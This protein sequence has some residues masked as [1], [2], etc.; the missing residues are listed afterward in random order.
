MTA[1]QTQET[2]EQVPVEKTP[3]ELA[4]AL[5][6]AEA[7]LAQAGQDFITFKANVRAE[8]MKMAVQHDLCTVV[9]QTLTKVGIGTEKRRITVTSTFTK[10]NVVDVPVELIQNLTPQTIAQ[11]VEWFIGN[12]MSRDLRRAWQQARHITTNAER[13][14]GEPVVEVSEVV[15]PAPRTRTTNTRATG[16]EAGLPEVAGYVWR[17]NSDDAR[18]L[19][20]VRENGA[21]DRVAALCSTSPGWTGWQVHS[22]RGTGQS[23][24]H[25]M[26][27]A[28]SRGLVR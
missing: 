28:R 23:C 13:P 12:N 3:E 11:Q 16:V 21:N 20:L 8:A 4:A 15:A 6:E 17:Y 24:G 2:T 7:K 9:E 25:C 27:I 18:R 22:L 19:H 26:R 1:T 10:V 14:V 5:A